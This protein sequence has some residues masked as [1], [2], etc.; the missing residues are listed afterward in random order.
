MVDS[1]WRKIDD[2]RNDIEN[3]IL[4]SSYFIKT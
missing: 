2:M 4:L 1:Y 3:S